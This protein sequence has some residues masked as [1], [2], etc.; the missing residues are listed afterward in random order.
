MKDG[1]KLKLRDADVTPRYIQE[2]QPSKLGYAQGIPIF[3]NKNIRSSFKALYFYFFTLYVLF[4][5]RHFILLSVLFCLLAVING[6]ILSF[7]VWRET[8][9]VFIAQNTLVFTLMLFLSIQIFLLLLLA[10]V[11][12]FIFCLELLV[13]FIWL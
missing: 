6:W 10:L 12:S 11:F 13:F 4:L 3:I 7:F 8:R 5:E 1:Q 9:S 2:L